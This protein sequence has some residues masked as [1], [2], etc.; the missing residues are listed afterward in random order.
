M[1]IASF[2]LCA[3]VSEAYPSELWVGL[4]ARFRGKLP[5]INYFQSTV[6]WTLEGVLGLG[7]LSTS[8]EASPVCKLRSDVSLLLGWS[9][10]LENQIPWCCLVYNDGMRDLARLYSEHKKIEQ[11]GTNEKVSE[12]YGHSEHS[13]GLGHGYSLKASVKKKE[14]SGVMYYVV[15]LEPLLEGSRDV[16]SITISDPSKDY[17]L[18]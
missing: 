3:R 17:E 14:V 8:V 16:A 13:L 15:C 5:E 10:D 9:L 2:G 12:I 4:A 18:I 6:P 11:N 7:L 1:S